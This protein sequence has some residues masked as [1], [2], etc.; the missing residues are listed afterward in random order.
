MVLV[1]VAQKIVF[2]I[3]FLPFIIAWHPSFEK[4]KTIAMKFI[5]R[6][7]VAI[8]NLLHQD[9]IAVKPVILAFRVFIHEDQY[10]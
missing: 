4:E 1:L 7:D 6:L 9:L 3:N 2:C 5:T 8:L 10:W